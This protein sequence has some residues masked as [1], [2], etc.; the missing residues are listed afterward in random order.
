MPNHFEVVPFDAPLGAEIKGLELKIDLSPQVQVALRKA[1]ADH[2]VL[3]VRGQRLGPEWHARFAA[4][5]GTPEA[6]GIVPGLDGH[7]VITEIRKEPEHSHNFGGAWHF[8]LSFQTSPPVAA[9]L[10]AREIPATGGDTLWANQYLA[11]E[12]LP[13]GVRAEVDKLVATHSSHLS[14][15]Q[16]LDAIQVSTARHPLA[17]VHPTTGRRHLFANPVSIESFIGRTAAES[18]ELLDFLV[19]HATSEAFQCRHRWQQD[20]VVVW[21]NRATMHRAMNDYQ[22]KRRVMHRIGIRG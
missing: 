7:D 12:A 19:E 21:D 14:F 17:P 8:D 2:L 16:Y 10:V 3:L 13:S 18:R 20:D 22:G 11:Y 15:N 6:H 9:V 5:F 4:C 1:L